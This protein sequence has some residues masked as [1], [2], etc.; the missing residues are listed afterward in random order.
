MKWVVWRVPNQIQHERDNLS[1]GVDRA[2]FVPPW[3]ACEGVCGIHYGA[4]TFE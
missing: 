4:K 2:S 1:S 3:I